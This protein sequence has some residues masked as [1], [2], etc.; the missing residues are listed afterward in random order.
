LSH[1]NSTVAH[2]ATAAFSGVQKVLA[3]RFG[4]PSRDGTSEYLL[5]VFPTIIRL[6]N[7]FLDDIDSSI[8]IIFSQT[9]NTPVSNRPYCAVT[10]AEEFDCDPMLA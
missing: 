8:F 7:F 2:P 9:K 1:A 10:V 4:T 3:E 6:S 5:W